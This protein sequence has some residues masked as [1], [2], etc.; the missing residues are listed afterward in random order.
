MKQEIDELFKAER[1]R[2][3]FNFIAKVIQRGHIRPATYIHEIGLPYDLYEAMSNANVIDHEYYFL[4]KTAFF[5][6]RNEEVIVSFNHLYLC[7]DFH[8]LVDRFM[9]VSLTGS[10]PVCRSGVSKM[11]FDKKI[12]AV[13]H[14]FNKKHS[15]K[16]IKL[17]SDL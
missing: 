11:N 9:I 2:D 3:N 15:G 8:H 5:E 10:Y 1:R 7:E 14:V 16:T 12:E 13:Q 4:S 6:F 17:K